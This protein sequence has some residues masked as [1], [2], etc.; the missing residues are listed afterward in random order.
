M[1]ALPYHGLAVGE[2]GFS[3]Y[4]CC[5]QCLYRVLQS[6]VFKLEFSNLSAQDFDFGLPLLL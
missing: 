1:S 2:F 3:R 5:G 6:A 4:K